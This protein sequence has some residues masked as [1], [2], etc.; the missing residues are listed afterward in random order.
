M[1]F[2]DSHRSNK[3]VHQTAQHRPQ[4]SHFLK[5]LYYVLLIADTHRSALFSKKGGSRDT[6][7]CLSYC[8]INHVSAEINF[9]LETLPAGEH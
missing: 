1:L 4:P 3:E 6:F 5:I 9:Q 2:G 8:L 7:L